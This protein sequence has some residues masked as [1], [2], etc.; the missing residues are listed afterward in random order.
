MNQ[1]LR[2][3]Y[4]GNNKVGFQILKYLKKIKENIVGLVLHPNSN[5]RYKS[6][7]IDL[8]PNTQII[9]WD[10]EKIK[11]IINIISELVPDI[12]ISTFFGYIL[13]TSL[14]EI[15]P[16]GAINL[17]PAYLPYNR[18]KNPNVWSI[19][20]ETP[21]GVALHYIDE[22]IDTGDIIVR[23]KI[24]TDYTDTGKSLYEKLENAC[25]DLFKKKWFTI[26]EGNIY[27]IKPEEPS[28]MHYGKDFYTLDEIYPNKEYKAIDLINI[29]RARTFP[30]YKGTF[31]KKNGKKYYMEIKIT[32]EN[33]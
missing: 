18:G 11:N 32:R 5:A 27:K 23:E 4:F 21:A 7:M 14:I 6:D 19:V 28:T 17:H 16:K 3:V 12:F 10:R 22:G 31:F 2:I 33:K 8:F 13:P 24:E 25:I 29:L 30:P 9:I 26:K 20:D 15:P 1:A